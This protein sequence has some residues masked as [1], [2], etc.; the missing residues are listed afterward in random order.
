VPDSQYATGIVFDD[1]NR[2]GVFD[3]GEKGL[4]GVRVSNGW[5]SVRTDSSGKYTIHIDADTIIFVIKPRDW[6][7]RTDENNV[8]RFYYIH[9]PNGSPKFKFKTVD[10]TGPL[11]E[12]IDF[13]LYRHPEPNR[14]STIFFSDTQVRNPKEINYLSHDIIEELVGSDA[15]FGVTLGDIAFDDLRVYEQLI[16]VIGKV[17]CPWYY[18]KGN[19]DTNYDGAPDVKLAD[20]TFERYFGP[21]HYSFDYGPVHFIALNNP[22]FGQKNGYYQ[23]LDFDQRM[24]LADDLAA[25]PKD[26]LVVLMMHIPL[27]DMTDRADIFKLLETHPNVF[28]ICGHNHTQSHR[29]ITKKDGWNGERPL[30]QYVNGTACGSFW[31]GFPDEVGIPHATMGDGTPN[32]YSVMTFD[33]I[34]YSIRFKAARKPD[35]YQMNIYAP[36]SVE[37]TKTGATEMLVNVFAGS[38]RSKVEMRFGEGD[39][40]N[41]E[42][43]S[44]TDPACTETKNFET[45]LGPYERELSDPCKSTHI[46]KAN[47]PKDVAPGTYLIQVRTTDMFGQTYKACRVINVK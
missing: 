5:S 23:K 35:N 41:M 47:L 45:S 1:A 32:G 28:T 34:S 8:P 18:V 4:E 6:Q 44:V 22:Y 33:G 43:V 10:P 21:S 3:I 46:W 2:N 12:S 17:G 42:L 14:F 9:K 25:I 20:E 7:T 26:Q 36:D 15:A 24:F 13:P 38:E 19:H 37:S 31:C 30:H 11:P 29:F 27:T 16:P 39:W 40:I